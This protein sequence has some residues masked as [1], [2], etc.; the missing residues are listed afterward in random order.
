MP[1]VEIEVPILLV[2]GMSGVGKSAIVKASKLT[3][4]IS[5]TTR[6]P[7]EGEEHAKDYFFCTKEYMDKSVK[8]TI[9]IPKQ[10][11]G[12]WYCASDLQFETKDCCIVDIDSALVLQKKIPSKIVWIEGEQRESR[13]DRKEPD[14][15]KYLLN[16]DYIIQN[17]RS[18][19]DA[20]ERLHWIHKKCISESVLEK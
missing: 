8:C 6:K 2:V 5:Y 18:I 3:E 7:R 17:D 1:I 10:N 12:N 19:E 4:V 15:S 11:Y 16:F 20:V 13:G 14:L 9:D